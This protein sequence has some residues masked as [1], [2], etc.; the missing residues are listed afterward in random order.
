MNNSSIVILLDNG[1]GIQ[2]PGK[3][4]PDGTL[5]EYKYTREIVDLI[6]KELQNK[7]LQAVKLVPEDDD[8]PLSQ[9]VKRANELYKKYNKEAILISVHCNAAGADGKWHNASGWTVFVAQNASSKSK[10][11]AST[12]YLEAK[13]NGLQGNR[14][15][16]KEKYWVQSLA[17]CRDTNC[18]AVLTENM[19]QDN[20]SDVE[21]LLSEEGKKK[22]VETHVNGILNYLQM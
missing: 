3:R 4:S 11:L 22:I 7:G 15:V 5:L 19:F 2:T 8:I 21:L 17:I 12:L 9:R 16:P 6:I 18:P 10:K 13:K 20:K 1:H 14:S